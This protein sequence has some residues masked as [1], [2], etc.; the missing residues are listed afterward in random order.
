MN[1]AARSITL[2]LWN[3]L[4]FVIMLLRGLQ[5]GFLH[6]YRLI[7][8]RSWSSFMVM[9]I[10][11][12]RHDNSQPKLLLSGLYTEKQRSPHPRLSPA[13]EASLVSWTMVH[14][15]LH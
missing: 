8:H 14:S 12:R 7:I 3:T 6:Q 1:M 4:D 10:I 13:E 2:S 9:V 15:L 11:H 5:P